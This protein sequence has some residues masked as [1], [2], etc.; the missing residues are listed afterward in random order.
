MLTDLTKL[1]ASIFRDCWHQT[2]EIGLAVTSP[3]SVRADQSSAGM[4]TWLVNL[5]PW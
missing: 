5:Q 2:S 3:Q 4:Y 1:S